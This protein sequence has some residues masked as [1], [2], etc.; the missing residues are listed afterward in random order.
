V[1]PIGIILVILAVLLVAL[2]VWDMTQR[3]H[4]VL[5]NFPLIGHFRYLLEKVGPEL[6]QYIVT[7]NDAERPFSR[8]ERTWIYASSKEQNNYSG[9]GTDADLERARGHVIVSHSTFPA[10]EPEAGAACGAPEFVLPPAIVLG[11]LHGRRHAFRPASIVNVSGMSFG[12]LSANAVEALNRGVA[13]AGCLQVTGE[14]GIAPAHRHGGELVFQLGTGYYGARDSAGRFSLPKLQSLV[15]DCPIRAIEVK[16]SQGAKPGHGGILPG[17]KVTAEIAAIR[18]VEQGVDCISPPG[19]AEF[20]DVDSMIDF[21]E[22]I[23]DATGLP[24]GIKSAVGQ[25]PFWHD[26]ARRMAARAEGPDFIVIDG[27]EGGTGA[28]P[29]VFADHVSLPFRVAMP[30]VYAAFAEHGLASRVP[31]IGSGRLGLPVNALTALTLGCDLVHVGREAMLSIGCIQAQRCHTGHCPTGVATQSKWLQRGLDPTLKSERAARY[32]RVLRKELLELAR[33][34]GEP[35]PAFVTAD[36]L[37]VLGPDSSSRTMADVYG[38]DPAHGLP[39]EQ[40]RRA[41]LEAMGLAPVVA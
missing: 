26:L 30:R 29:Y 27:G 41:V 3:R 23:A 2:A 39:T 16:L 38:L 13:L 31:F 10:P 33:T 12:A 28:A 36:R 9:F 8:D 14:G 25:M 40:D 6:R 22:R 15:E 5:R 19:H 24:V 11:E 17:A 1:E 21:I 37:E 18:G 7:A 34:C 4:A 35:H 32:I 20:S